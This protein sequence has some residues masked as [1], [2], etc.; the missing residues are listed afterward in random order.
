L[1]SFINP[2]HEKR[3]KEI[4]TEEF[5]EVYVTLSSELVP[6]FREYSRMSTAVLNAY[7]GPVMEKYIDKFEK[8]IENTG[9]KV[10]PY[11]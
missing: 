2:V 3:I 9:I 11:V 6:E 4:I 10:A 1:F 5:P 8:S 7:L